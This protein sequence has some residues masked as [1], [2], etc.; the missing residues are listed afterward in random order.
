[1]AE[2]VRPTVVYFVYPCS[3]RMYLP[4]I[5]IVIMIHSV[6]Q[7]EFLKNLSSGQDEEILL[8]VLEFFFLSSKL[9]S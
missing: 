4:G 9:L 3:C 5:V 1:M 7:I 8:L 2:G 6:I